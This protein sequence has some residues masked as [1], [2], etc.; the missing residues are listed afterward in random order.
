MN[1]IPQYTNY[2]ALSFVLLKGIGSSPIPVQVSVDNRFLYLSTNYLLGPIVAI[3]SLIDDYLGSQSDLVKINKKIYGDLLLKIKSLEE[4]SE[5]SRYKLDDPL[6]VVR[7][8]HYLTKVFKLKE[9]EGAEVSDSDLLEA[10]KIATEQDDLV[11][12]AYH[13]MVQAL[14]KIPT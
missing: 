12:N 13:N 10:L 9:N 3:P 2:P 14:N 5:N 1:D 4:E 11:K 6:L 7:S 8:F